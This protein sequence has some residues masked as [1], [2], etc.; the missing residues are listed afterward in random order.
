MTLPLGMKI[1]LENAERLKLGNIEEDFSKKK[2]DEI[3]EARL[4]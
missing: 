4:F 2:L 1:S 3:I